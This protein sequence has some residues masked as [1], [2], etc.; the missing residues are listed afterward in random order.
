M[1]IRLSL[2]SGDENYQLLNDISVLDLDKLKISEKGSNR[3][4]ESEL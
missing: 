4:E 2:S 1:T 3:Y